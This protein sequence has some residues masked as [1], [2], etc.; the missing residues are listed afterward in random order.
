MARKRKYNP[1]DF[2]YRASFSSSVHCVVRDET[3]PL[4]SKASLESIREIIPE[5]FRKDELYLADI[6][7]IA[8]NGAVVG[9]A[10]KNGDLISK[11]SALEIA[12]YF[13]DK[14]LD[15]DHDNSDIIGHLVGVGYSVFG[16]NEVLKLEDLTDKEV[17][18]LT[19]SAVVYTTVRDNLIETL[20]ESADPTSDLYN[21]ISASWEIL[22]SEYD[23]MVGSKDI[24]MAKIISEEDKPKYD[25]FLKA[26]G[27]NGFDEE[28]NPV[29]RILKGKL[30]PLGFGLVTTPAA[31]VQGIVTASEINKESTDLN[32]VIK[33]NSAELND[34]I[35]EVVKETLINENR[36]GGILKDPANTKDTNKLQENIQHSNNQ[37]V[38]N[39][40][41]ISMNIKNLE[42]LKTVLASEAAK[43]ELITSVASLFQ[44]MQD[45]MTSES[46]K[47]AA[48]K[49]EKESAIA[50]QKE[51]HENLIKEM[52]EL[53]ESF[54]NTQSELA[55]IKEDQE[56]AVAQEVFSNRMAEF[57][58]EYD[59]DDEDRQILA[60]DLKDMTEESFAA[61]KKKMTKLM[62][63]KKKGAMKSNCK[64][65]GD[66][67]DK[68]KAS[69]KDETKENDLID[70]ALSNAKV[71]DTNDVITNKPGNETLSDKFKKAFAATIDN[72]EIK[73][74]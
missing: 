42:D 55:K 17:F 24:S 71:T 74:A 51:D 37:S 44:E 52:A 32:N 27:G 66:M 45:K 3:N 36:K 56:K 67:D 43:P 10:N 60:E 2:K 64:K 12:P 14:Y 69:V 33:E 20:E 23:I 70:K 18:N 29:S 15:L 39:L 22:F 7:P 58:A 21:A 62:S 28:G 57:D 34:K 35:K 65:D 48:E 13:V 68:S 11:E 8:F 54:E 26:N 72:K 19:L 41:T 31:F 9:Y 30:I 47:W 63:A 61:Y 6:L 46:E 49:A 50:K 16:S 73:L 53:K 4:L 38:S 25:K 40:T 59:L 5:K 1:E